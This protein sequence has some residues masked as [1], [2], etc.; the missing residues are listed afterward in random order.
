MKLFAAGL[1]SAMLTLACIGC[2]GGKP[3][4]EKSAQVE[5][6]RQEEKD[7]PTERVSFGELTMEVPSSWTKTEENADY[8]IWE[9]GEQENAALGIVVYSWEKLNADAG[10]SES[11]VDLLVSKDLIQDNIIL[12]DVAYKKTDVNGLP[13]RL[14]EC[15]EMTQEGTTLHE[16]SLYVV[17]SNGIV[18]VMARA[19]ESTQEKMLPQF[20][21]VLK[22]VSA[23][24]GAV[25]ALNAAVK[26][27]KF[28][29]EEIEQEND[30]AKR[31]IAE[32]LAG[33]K[34]WLDFEE[35]AASKQDDKKQQDAAPEKENSGEASSAE[36]PAQGG[37]TVSQ[38]NAV[39]K[40][41]QYLGFTH[42]SRG[43]LIDQLMFEQFSEEDA[44][45]AADHCGA[46]WNE[47]A[48]DKAKDYLG[49]SAFSHDGLIG[50][51]E[52]DKF[53]SEQATYAADN[54][55]ADW[56]EQAAKKA[57]EYLGFMSF[58]RDGLI[59]QLVFDGFTSDQAA[60][61]ARKR[62]WTEPRGCPRLRSL[63]AS[64]ACVRSIRVCEAAVLHVHGGCGKAA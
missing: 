40:A 42:F 33:N 64:G 54:C 30:L 26:D 47:Q 11:A 14:F 35:E 49:F 20:E 31:Q 17:T 1:A 45:Y 52:F 32:V 9:A 61:G 27:T 51:L 60:Y 43:G 34:T 15:D 62:G 13:A 37:P 58:S 8:I 41:K 57:S 10:L 7:Q 44:A 18:T 23:G 28:S 4:E 39:Q 56:N 59:N 36:S 48:L 63:A 12:D 25:D 6:A 16:T 24:D 46:D 50:Q 29:K 19:D 38:A 2:S 5:E 55:G 22:S 21:A 53:T 3:A